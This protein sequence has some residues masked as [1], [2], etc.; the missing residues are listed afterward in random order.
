MDITTNNHSRNILCFFDLTEREQ[1]D[2][3]GNYSSI[4]EGFFFR[5]RGRV[6]DLN[7]FMR[8]NN[9]S[10]FPS[11]WDGYHSDTFFS[12]TLIKYSDCG[13]KIIVATAMS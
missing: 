6:Y 11:E 9:N 4:E 8:N 12:A 5:Y 2:I 10:P 3:K 7:D 1:E 13:D